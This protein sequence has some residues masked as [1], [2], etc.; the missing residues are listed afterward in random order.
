MKRKIIDLRS[1]SVTKPSPEMKK[2]MYEAEVGDD[3][4]GED[5]SVNELEEYFANLA[6]KEKALF[7]PSGTMA[8]QL[9]LKILSEPGDEV[10]CEK[11]SHIFI[12]ESGS[13]AFLSGLQLYPIDG[14][15][16]ALDPTEVEKV[17]RPKDAYYMPRTKIIEVENTH[18][19]AG[20]TIIPIENIIALRKLADKHNLF[21]HLDGSRLWHAIV[22]TGI[23]LREYAS[24]FETISCCLSKGLGAPVGSIIASNKELIEKGRRF[25]KAWG[26]GMR[27]IG[28]LAAAGL[29]AIQNNLQKLKDDH[30]KAKTFASL[31]SNSSYIKVLNNP[32]QTNIVLF[33]LN[34][35]DISVEYFL[36]ELK[37][38]GILF[39]I[40]KAQTLRAVFHLDISHEEVVIAA[41][42][43]L[44]LNIKNK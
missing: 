39:S 4:Y 14:F 12:Y 27:Q 17:I 18:N 42:E 24:Y 44:S 20:G 25:R 15:N 23:S 5:P 30:L 19:R 16:G 2:A 28:S 36:N 40:S 35:P 7:V 43:V 32:P 10:V 11:D 22:E 31:L 34:D 3:V 9:C 29:Y 13:P 1:D 33:Q 8:N 21:M 37:H 6:G 38:K 26:G 41:D